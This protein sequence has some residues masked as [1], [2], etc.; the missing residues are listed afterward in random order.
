MVEITG[1]FAKAEGHTDFFI[2][3][4][5][6]IRR[7]GWIEFAPVMLGAAL[8]SDFEQPIGYALVGPAFSREATEKSGNVGNVAQLSG[9][10]RRERLFLQFHEGDRSRRPGFLKCIMRS[11]EFI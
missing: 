1:M 9:E 11:G 6:R 2:T 4:H 10:G 7:Q 5:R 8:N 3:E